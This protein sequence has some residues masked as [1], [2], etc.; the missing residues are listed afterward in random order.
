MS[1]ARLARFSLALLLAALVSGCAPMIASAPAAVTIAPP[2]ASP[3]SGASSAAPAVVP[4]RRTPAGTAVA[5]PP[6]ATGAGPAPTRPPV[7]TV[8]MP[9]FAD[10]TREAKR[11]AGFLPVWSKD[12]KTWI[13][14]PTERLGKPFFLA[15]SVATGLGE[16]FFW[17][18][19]MGA[20]QVVEFRR[21]GNNVQLVARNLGVRAG[22]DVK[23]AS[24]L[25]ES[26]SDSL[27]AWAPMAAQVH[28]DRKSLLIDAAAL[29]FNDLTGAQTL[30]EASYRLPYALDR[31]NTSITRSQAS[32]AGTSFTV[33]YHFVIPKLPAPAAFNPSGPSP[34]PA[35]QPNPPRVVP[36]ARSLFV[37][38]AYTMAPLPEQP[39]SSRTADPRVGYFVSSFSDFS[40][41]RQEGRR[42]HL[43]RRWRLEKQDPG[44]EISPPKEPIR[45]VMDRNIPLKWRP[46]LR[47]GILEW[48]KAF[49]RAGFRNAITVEQQADADPASTLEGTRVLAVRWF[50]QEGPGSTAVGP[51]QSDPRTGE[52]L[53]GAAIIDE[54]RVRVMRLR[55]TESVS[56][57]SERLSQSIPPAFAHRPELPGGLAH[58]AP[59][60]AAGGGGGHTHA[61]GQEVC[62][63]GDELAE[64]AAAALELLLERGQIQAAS[65]QAD[66]F[67][68]DAL[69]QV[70]MHEVGHVLG[71]RHNFRASASVKLAQ[72]RDA[73]WIK[74]NALS[75]TVMEYLPVNMP[76]DGEPVTPYFQSTLGAYDYW[77][78]EYGYRQWPSAELE[79]Q[80]LQAL[81]AR[82]A[83]DPM[84]AYATD[85]DLANNDPSVHQRD[86]GD[87]P[88]AWAQREIKLGR[89]LFARTTA[90]VPQSGDD[91]TITRR[92]FGRYF[93][94][95]ATS[96]PLAVKSIGGF[97]TSRVNGLVHKPMLAP[98]PSAQ[99]RLALDMVLNEFLKSAAFRFDPVLMGRIGVD[100][101]ERFGPGRTAGVDFSIPQ[102]VSNLQKAALDALMADTLAGRL[103]DAEAHV[104][105]AR[106][107]LSFSEVQDKLAAAVWSELKSGAGGITID[108]LRRNVQ[109]EHIKRLA[110][111]LVRPAPATA[112]DVRAVHRQTALRLQT[113][114]QSALSAKAPGL[115][116]LVRAHLEDCVATLNEAL[117]APLVKQG[118]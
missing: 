50:V 72:L 47:E 97:H 92:A 77:A 23:L 22:S 31:G 32:A 98:V 39:M 118:A 83:A 59:A 95:M 56:R 75:P 27:I 45:V 70:T 87:D 4:S 7:P 113:Q 76:L 44:A 30:L 64:D 38:Y 80:G 62:S 49:E 12:D 14:I 28:P 24:T 11:S 37:S 88:L 67:I 53:R 41:D 115:S 73:Q 35:S 16:R 6:A 102:Q 79:K 78:I 63:Y 109:R 46:A 106:L 26:Y 55:A 107:L 94:S 43:I 101:F 1:P 18:G 52:M 8:G 29:L 105:D 112:A 33:R 66:Q 60:L 96:L 69:K 104:A 13:E 65:P 5:P 36:D 85:E 57:W 110:A 86:L 84:L 48:N 3:T 34:N 61:P 103:A 89:E 21:V 74:R 99:Q 10:V 82:A 9:A 71:L 25:A 40:D 42:T 68:Y 15:S 54:N 90:K 20:S 111:G 108:S 17:P 51:S 93:N 91:D 114:L 2:S 81:L 58:A 116:S 19:L 117:K 100:H